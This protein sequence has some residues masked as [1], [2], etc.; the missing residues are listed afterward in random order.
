MMALASQGSP[1][2][3]YRHG[4]HAGGFADVLKHAT[5]VHALRHAV[6]TPKPIY[7]L[8][9][10][11]GAGSY[12]L[13]STMA[14]KTGEFRAGIGRV[15]GTT[16]PPELLAPF[17]DLVRA[18][19]PPGE[20]RSYPGSPA[21]ARAVLRPADRL[22]LVELH[23]TDHAA[24]ADWGGSSATVRREDGLAALVA[25]LPPRERRAVVLVDPSY[26]VKSDYATV[27]AALARAHRRFPLGTYL[28]WY[29]VI[30]RAR[31]DAVLERLRQTGIRRQFRLELCLRPDASARGMTGAGLVVINPAWSLPDLA[32]EAL[33]W[34]ARALGAEGPVTSD[35]LVPPVHPEE[36]R[37]TILYS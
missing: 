22:E 13:N 32:A 36:N 4:Y 25:R 18:A 14:A 6:R 29:P 34:L 1:M 35:W 28:L 10:H 15:L 31:T 30:D 17:L 5:L 27:P 16:G 19:N 3:S 23:G 2:L 26:E 24:L 11:A 9:T 7:V 8:D 21:L 12:D 37:S 33:P 20:L